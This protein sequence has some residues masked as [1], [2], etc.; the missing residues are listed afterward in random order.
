M[1]ETP[2]TPRVSETDGVG[3]VNNVF[4]PIWFEAGRRE[5]FRILTPDL[6]FDR[7]RVA[8]VNMNVDYLDQIFFQEEALV[9]T[10]VDRIGNKSF[11][12]IEEVWQGERHCAN[13]TATYVY[14]NY[15]TGLSEPVPLDCRQALEAH[16]RQA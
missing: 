11:T 3:H 6:S 2:I 10:W 14:F 13:G 7:W 5:I 4:V 1:F 8:L 16:R 15:E 9:R 12:L